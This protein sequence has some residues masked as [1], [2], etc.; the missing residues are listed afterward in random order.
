MIQKQFLCLP[1]QE[2]D[3]NDSPNFL[4][5]MFAVKNNFMDFLKAHSRLFS[6]PPLMKMTIMAHYDHVS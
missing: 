5:V 1:L 2:S 4:S 6:A 3:F